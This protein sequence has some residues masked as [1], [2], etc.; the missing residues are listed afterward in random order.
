MER[1]RARSPDTHNSSSIFLLL[2]FIYSPTRAR[3][4]FSPL[5]TFFTRAQCNMLA[6]PE[7]PQ[8][9]PRSASLF[10]PTICIYSLHAPRL[11]VIAHICY[12]RIARMRIAL[13][14][15]YSP[16]IGGGSV[17]LRSHLAQL[18]DL[19]VEWYYLSGRSGPV[20]NIGHW[21]GKP[22]SRPA[23]FAADLASQKRLFA[24][25]HR[26]PR[27]E[28]SLGRIGRGSLLDRGALRGHLRGC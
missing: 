23:Q 10:Q 11:G 28:I 6:F 5:P 25:F 27:R 15:P 4:N 16:E 3:D 8:A 22:I 14:T 20:A 19:D 18:P 21:L 2:V 24:R 12:I 13:F 17:Q 9:N 1:A 26:V 7:S